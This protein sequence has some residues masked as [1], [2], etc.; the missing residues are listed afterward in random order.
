VIDSQVKV[1]SGSLSSSFFQSHAA[2][3]RHAHFRSVNGKVHGE[4]GKEQAGGYEC[5]QQEQCLK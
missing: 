1:K 4:N 2:Q 3:R 5:S